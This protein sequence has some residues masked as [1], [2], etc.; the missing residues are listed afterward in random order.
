MTEAIKTWIARQVR[1]LREQRDWSQGDL[2]RESGKKQS[3]ISRIEDPDYGQLTLQ[4]LF[5][6]AAAFDLP[7]LVQFAEWP[8]WLN[9][10]EDVS[11]EW[12]QRESFNEAELSNLSAQ[13][14]TVTGE[15]IVR[16]TNINWNTAIVGTGHVGQILVGAFSTQARA[17]E[18]AKSMD[19]SYGDLQLESFPVQPW[20]AAREQEAGHA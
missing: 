18:V 16:L 11:T 9:R 19:F 8:D 15:E 12:L 13:Q 3:N 14:Y 20:P 7:L 4:T 10:M 17:I 1:A 6:L 2:A 5:D